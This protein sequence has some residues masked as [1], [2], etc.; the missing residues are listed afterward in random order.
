MRT[1]TVQALVGSGAHVGATSFTL[2]AQKRRVDFSDYESAFGLNNLLTDST[3][4]TNVPEDKKGLVDIKKNSDAYSVDIN[5]STD[6]VLDTI[7]LLNFL[8]STNYYAEAIAGA[9]SGGSGNASVAG[10]FAMLFFFNST[11]AL[12]GDNAVIT[13]TGNMDVN[14]S[15]D[16]TARIIAG[17]LSG[18]GSKVGV[19]LT[20]G[21]LANS[22]EVTAS[23]GEGAQIT[24][25]GYYKQNATANTDFMVI[26]VAAAVS[27]GASGNTVGGAIDC[28][29][30]TSDVSSTVGDNAVITAGGDVN[31]TSGANSF[32]LLV[33]LSASG[34]GGVAVGGTLAVIISG[35]EVTAEVGKSAQLTSNGG[36]IAVTAANHEKLVSALASAS[37]STG[38]TAVAGT[39]NVLITRSLTRALVDS[40]AVLHANKDISVLAEGD[41]WMLVIAMA[42]SG[43]SSN[44]VG[45]TVSVGVFSRTVQASV[46]DNASLTA[47]NGNI[48]VQALGKDW[49]LY[50]T[51]AAGASGN[52]AFTGVIPVVVAQNT[53]GASAGKNS[54][55][56]AG[57]SIGIIANLDTHLYMIGGGLAASGSNAVGATLSAAILK[58]SVS[59]QVGD[60]AN[61]LANGILNGSADAAGILLPNRAA[62]RRGVLISATANEAVVLVAVAA[63]GSGSVAV[64]GVVNT[65]VMRN[66]V[67]AGIG[68]GARA[69][70]PGSAASYTVA[71]DGGGTTTVTVT[72]DVL[73]EAEDDSSSINLAG[74]LSA[75]GDVGVGATIV[76]LVFDRTVEATVAA[77]A[78]VNAAGNVQVTASAND[79]LWLLAVAF[80]AAGT[81]GV[82]GGANALVF[83]NHVHAVLGG[84]A[85]AG[86]DIT[87]SAYT[88]SLLVNIAA[89]AGIGG[90]VGVTAIALITYFYNETLAYLKA[91]ASLTATGSVNVKADS[92]E[93]VTA[94]AAG[95][96]GSGTVSVGGTLDVIVV[97]VVTKAYTEN[98]VT[99][100]G[101]DI[102]VKATDTCTIVAVVVTAAVSGVVGVG[103]SAL[104]VVFFN[105]VS[106]EVGAGSVI[107]AQRSISVTANSNR[108]AY[109]IVMTVGGGQ[110]GVAGTIAVVVAGSALTSDA[111]NGIYA[112]SNGK[113]AM[114]P[115]TQTNGVFASGHSEAASS[116]PDD[117]L[118]DML[119]SNGQ[120]ANNLGVDGNSYGQNTSGTTTSQS[121]M[122][123][124][125][126]DQ[127][128]GKSQSVQAPGRTRLRAQG[129]HLSRR[130]R[131]R[132]AYR[133]YGQYRC[134]LG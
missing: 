23:V 28:I 48:L 21:A 53:I 22:D 85:T 7:D 42:L 16:T 87:V 46:G 92:N 51:M 78:T 94:D 132:G 12:V 38:G 121:G 19:G 127:T 39:L 41:A 126:Y 82:A 43:A 68:I 98:T 18:S 27:T 56:T 37:A 65:I 70:A 60:Y 101:Y 117:S 102:N 90:T 13:L 93:L 66:N 45:A 96:S 5:I 74:S 77:G 24:A 108:S 103:I 50:I 3:G 83:T 89:A 124:T 2:S 10:S 29:V 120:S 119:A 9:I 62:R 31:I 80:G 88:K 123:D 128:A 97:R 59:A 64:T 15:A 75:S 73:V 71:K 49:T 14:A 104:A 107:T 106:A 61:L 58:S 109:A 17:A 99:V 110:V 25:D 32:L 30:Q 81:V 33:S 4:Q 79:S 115:Q 69:R 84:T 134:N 72:C 52:N 131:R 122:N 40:G 111:H 55:L 6:K 8:S 11:Q 112:S 1:N 26:T 129:R 67:Q 114:D 20:V 100:S 105:T 91:N 47:D 36:S 95:A 113:S 54:G 44:A 76:A 63:A 35:S 133:Q 125:L 116:K 130:A 86:G 118:D 34:S 57:D